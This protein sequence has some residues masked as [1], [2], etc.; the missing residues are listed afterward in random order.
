MLTLHRVPQAG[1]FV[2]LQFKTFHVSNRL[3]AVHAGKAPSSRATCCVRRRYARHLEVLVQ[4]Q[5]RPEA[6]PLDGG[7]SLQLAGR[8]GARERGEVVLELGRGNVGVPLSLHQGRA[9]VLGDAAGPSAPPPLG[10]AVSPQC[11]HQ[12]PQGQAGDAGTHQV[13]HPD[14]RGDLARLLHPGHAGDCGA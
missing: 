13:L 12:G 2:S 9:Q 14:T 11:P 5:L 1:F 10:V 4:L 7:F 8:C 6:I 3:P